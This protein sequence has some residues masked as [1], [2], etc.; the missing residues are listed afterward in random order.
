MRQIKRIVVVMQAIIVVLFLTN[1]QAANVTINGLIEYQVIDGFGVSEAWNYPPSNILPYLFDDL[2]ISIL[3]FRMMPSLESS[4]DNSN[5]NDIDWNNINT[6]ALSGDFLGLLQEA[7]SKNIPILGTIWS[8]PAW[9]KTNGQLTNGGSVTPGYE[10]EFVEYVIIWIKALENLGIYMDYI[11]IQNEPDVTETWESCRYNGGELNDAIKLV[12]NR[13]ETEGITT[14]LI[15]PD[16]AWWGGFSSR[17]TPICEDTVTTNYV[18]ILCT[19]SYGQ[20]YND[21]DSLISGWQPISALAKSY[22]KRLWMTEYSRP[23]SDNTRWDIA[24]NMAQHMHNA[25]A[26]ADIN[27]YIPWEFYSTNMEQIIMPGA[28]T[29]HRYH[30]QKQYIKYIRPGAVR[31]DVRSG[32]PDILVTGFNNKQNDTVTFVAINRKTNSET[33]N[34]T[35][36]NLTGILNLNIIRTSQTDSSLNIGNVSVSGNSFTYDLPGQSVTTFTGHKGSTQIK[37][38]EYKKNDNIEILVSPNPFNSSTTIAIAINNQQSAG[39]PA[40]N[41]YN[42]RGVLFEELT[43]EYT[44]GNQVAGAVYRGY[45]WNASNLPSGVY[46]V[47]AIIGTQNLQKK[48]LL[49]K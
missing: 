26:H 7:K 8:P 15:G 29:T 45:T 23:N 42:L 14:K 16:N 5:P 12:G 13:F 40:V 22:N 39:S 31:I 47:K 19:H 6:G 25:L 46:V 37:R 1:V 27:A 11:S 10:D 17:A 41:I 4:N 3:R 2:G 24:I 20:S 32:D 44:S 30:A 18:D 9:M 48:V 33:A 49:I 28:I 21:P 38:T 36:N 43:T 35:I 34:F